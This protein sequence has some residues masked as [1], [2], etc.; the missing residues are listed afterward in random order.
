MPAKRGNSKPGDSVALEQRNRFNVRCMRK[1]VHHTRALHAVTGIAHEHARVACQCCRIA[2]DVHNALGQHALTAV[3]NLPQR[4]RYRKRTL[5]RW[6]DENLV[7]GTQRAKIVGCDLEEVSAC[8]RRML[9]DTIC[10][11]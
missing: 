6:I 5:T 1:H 11:S 9:M 2:G 8:E 10:P 4:L 7:E 3:G